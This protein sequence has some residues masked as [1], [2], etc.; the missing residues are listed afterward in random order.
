M[1]DATPDKPI[2]MQLIEAREAA[3]IARRVWESAKAAEDVARQAWIR[4]HAE[5]DRLSI[6]A[7]R[8]RRDDEL[9]GG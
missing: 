2:A 4:A 8:S 6:V 9:R 7:S 5:V 1:K 3:V